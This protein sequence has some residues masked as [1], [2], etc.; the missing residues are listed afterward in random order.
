MLTD[1]EKKAVIPMLQEVPL[2]SSLDKKALNYVASSAGKKTYK[3]GDKIA[4]EGEKAIS[5]YLILDGSVDVRRGNR[6]IAK[7]GKGQFFGE[8]ALFDDQPRSADVV[9][10]EDTTCVLLTS[11]ALSGIIADNPKIAQSIIKELVR[12]LRETD[13]ALSE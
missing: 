6:I 10:A 11:W 4:R 9:A 5:F 13:K 7:L 1:S 12:R 2:F 3:Q 8:M